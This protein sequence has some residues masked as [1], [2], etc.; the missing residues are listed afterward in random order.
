MDTRAAIVVLMI[1]AVLALLVTIMGCTSV[2]VAG[3]G[4]T[5]KEDDKISIWTRKD[6]GE[7]R[8]QLDCQPKEATSDKPSE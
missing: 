2:M 8:T 7:H 5:I 3:D 6:S 4:C 1:L